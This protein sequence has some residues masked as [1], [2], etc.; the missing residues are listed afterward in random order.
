VQ[1]PRLGPGATLARVSET[2]EPP[3]EFEEYRI[4][5]SLGR[6]GMGHVYLAH[7]TLLDRP[8]A[9]KFISAV[10]PDA[11]VRQQFFTEA[12]AIARLTHPNVVT[13]YRV[14]EVRRQP[15]LVSE[16][17]RGQ[18]LDQIERPLSAPRAIG[19]A[20][21]LASGLA[22]AHRRGVLHRDIKPA[23]AILT[24]EGEPKL[25]DFGLAKLFEPGAAGLA[26][27]TT[28]D[29][30]AA[31]LV[32]T[33][34]YMAPEIWRGEAPSPAADIY[35]FG[36]MLFELV[37]GRAFGEAVAPGDLAAV[38]TG[39]AQ[40]IE[41]CLLR[42]PAGRYPNGAALR[43]ALEPLAQVGEAATPALPAGNPYPGLTSFEPEHRAL[44]FGR[45]A[46]VRAIVDRLR[47]E[48]FV[49]V[50][51]DSGVGKSSLCA[52]GVAAALGDQGWRLARLVPGRRPLLALAAAIAHAV[53][54]DETEVQSALSAEPAALAARLART[55][56]LLIFVDQ[57][58]ELETLA[59]ADEAELFAEAW[60]ALAVTRPGLRLLATVRG[61]FLTRLGRLPAWRELI[62]PALY[63]LGPIDAEGVRRAIVAPAARKGVRFETEALVTQLAQASMQGPGGLPLLQFALAALWDAR[64]AATGVIPG[65]ALAAMGGVDGALA[66]H[67][68]GVIARLRPAER[69]AARPLLTRLVT[70]D[71]TRARY[72]Q[73]EL[74][75]AGDRLGPIVL[76]ALVR[77]RLLVVRESDDNQAGTYEIAHEA[78]ITRWDTLRAWLAEKA[79]ARAA[80]GRLARAAGEWTRL[81]R[82][83]E[84]LLSPRQLQEIDRTAGVVLGPTESDFVKTSRKR[85]RRQ[86]VRIWLVSGT[87][88]LALVAAL[89]AISARAR[90][91]QRQAVAARL[92]TADAAMAEARPG[93]ARLASVN[94]G[95]FAAFDHGDRSLGERLWAEG[96]ELGRQRN[97]AWARA[98]IALESALALDPARLDVRRRM[99]DLLL[100]RILGGGQD[101]RER[102]ELVGR[103]AAYDE[104]G[105]RVQR[106]SAPAHLVLR[107]RPGGARVTLERIRARDGRLAADPPRALGTTP[108][109]AALDA[110]SYVI[111]LELAGRAPVHL[112]LLLTTGQTVEPLIDLPAARDVPPDFV[113]VPAG[114]F[115][116]GSADETL[117]RK[118]LNA[119]PLHEV[120]TG[121]YLIARHEVTFAQWLAFLDDL[122]PPER[123]RRRPLGS[124]RSHRLE[125]RR[126]GGRWLFELA[127]TGYAAYRARAGEMIE[128]VDRGRRARQDWRRFPVAGI[129]LTD[130]RAFT[131][132]LDRTG[133]VPA[134]RLC[135][136][137]EWERAARGADGRA[138]PM[139]ERVEPDD[140]NHD[141]TYDFRVR[142]L[143]PD[144][145][146]SH[147]ASR[148]PLGLDD[149]AGNAFEWVDG[150]ATLP[151]INR[152]GSWRQGEIVARLDNREPGDAEIRLPDLGMRVCATPRPHDRTPD[153]IGIA[154]EE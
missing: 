64:D 108:A 97:G 144:E 150:A 119:E 59:R 116:F 21:G 153:P 140:F 115:L 70:P 82:P 30:A 29:G 61:D 147:A 134:A 31:S 98:G 85:R 40:V 135:S 37:T 92:A 4:V 110:G 5:R 96:I 47:A 129:S 43:E 117:R 50:A 121:A 91:A 20:I 136:E 118:F 73:D 125:L 48:A 94:R 101:D 32:G 146:G 76:E 51:G 35:G 87:G 68:D 60:A 63:M 2:F 24:D 114:R 23:N 33:P 104:G 89:F 84:L 69:A 122:P 56:P 127:P 45:D 123:E 102:A 145:V 3:A 55:G 78:L 80:E 95:A 139:G 7:D 25:L 83:A 141:V 88:T 26:P 54:G 148:S 58:E 39:L 11:R 142:A 71:G 34:R 154:T 17:V 109:Q 8:V 10:S 151:A 149:M 67:A 6:G 57:L 105:L 90:Q 53:N 38:P 143:G 128:Y 13:V 79:E 52:A 44:F 93:A 75:I 49:L 86:R 112:P 132:W 111:S 41:R 42:E 130:A 15:Y 77:G 120:E 12:R 72:R 81:G 131:A 138:F 46:D 1:N 16:Y 106:L 22:A 65:A 113:F 107:S 133:R 66:H 103:L 62:G 19:I 14:G 74:V 27:E 126:A 36:V 9:V 124:S 99:A 137:R 18:P 28:L 152:G 100:D